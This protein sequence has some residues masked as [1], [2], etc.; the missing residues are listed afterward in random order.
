MEKAFLLSDA[1]EPLP[2]SIA[3]RTQL[4]LN[5]AWLEIEKPYKDLSANFEAAL[6]LVESSQG[7]VLKGETQA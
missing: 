4:N 5:R 7:P 6:D 3:S 2:I 1:A